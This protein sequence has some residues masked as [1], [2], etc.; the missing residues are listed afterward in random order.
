MTVPY[1][2]QWP[3]QLNASLEEVDP[4]LY[5]IIEKEKNRQFKVQSVLRLH[6]TR[7]FW[8]CPFI[9]HDTTSLSLA[10]S[11]YG[12]TT[13][14]HLSSHALQRVDIVC[15]FTGPG[16]HSLRKLCVVISNGSGWVCYD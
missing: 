12:Q 3:K 14:V 1:V 9:M 11:T 2:L 7:L 5:D 13:V 10:H 15:T 6:I 4:E 16:A 8:H